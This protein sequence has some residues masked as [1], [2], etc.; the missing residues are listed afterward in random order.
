LFG[1]CVN[2]EAAT[3][4]ISF[5]LFGLLRIFAAFDATFFD[6]DSFLAMEGSLWRWREAGGGVLPRRK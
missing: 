4:F 1:R 2:A 3:A 5:E 6:V